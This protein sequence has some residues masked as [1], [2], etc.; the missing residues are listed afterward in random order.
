MTAPAN[1]AAHDPSPC[2]RDLQTIQYHSKSYS[3]EFTCPACGKHRRQNTNYLGSRRFVMCDGVTIKAG[4]KLEWDDYQ[5]MRARLR[6]TGA[7]P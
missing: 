4:P 7:T 1:T 5:I 3:Y 2:G 6:A